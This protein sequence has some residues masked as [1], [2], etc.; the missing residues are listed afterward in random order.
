MALPTTTHCID[1]SAVAQR[2]NGFTL[3]E[4]LVVISII[5]ILM[6][7]LLPAVQGAREAARRNT[8]SNNLRQIGIAA[9]AHETQ[10]GFLPTGGWGWQWAGDP[11]QG[12]SPKQPGGF[13]FNILPFMEQSVVRSVGAGMSDQQKYTAL[14]QAAA[15]PIAIRN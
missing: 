3:V 8:C 14:G 4:L 7:L 15:T 2:V 12:F 9:L 13:F 5:G 6:S 11:D 1:R 10:M